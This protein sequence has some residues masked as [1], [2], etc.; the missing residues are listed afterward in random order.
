M[1]INVDLL[2][3]ADNI[4]NCLA[5]ESSISNIKMQRFFE[6]ICHQKKSYENFQINSSVF[7]DMGFI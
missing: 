5:V 7:D 1:Q 2:L 4:S 6:N 3:K